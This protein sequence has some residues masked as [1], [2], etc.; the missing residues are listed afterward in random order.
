MR[1][2]LNRDLGFTESDR[3]ENIRRVGEVAALIADA[4][5]IVL[6]SASSRPTARNATWRGRCCPPA[7]SWRCSSTPPIDECRR[8]DPKGLYEKAVRGE[9][10]N[11]TGIS[12]P[13]EPPLAPDIRLDTAAAAAETLADE[14]V[15]ALKARRFIA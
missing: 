10:P 3:V 7:S 8:R 1:H 12:A 14:V 6:V 9:I 2:G 11:F 15:R 4:G 13:Y 5:L